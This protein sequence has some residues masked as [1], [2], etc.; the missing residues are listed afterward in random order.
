MTI[1]SKQIEKIP[2]G[3]RKGSNEIRLKD[4]NSHD[5]E[6][7][8]QAI[9]KEWETNLSNGAIKAVDPQRAQK[10]RQQNPSRIMQS[11]LLHVAKPIMT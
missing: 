11:R 3:S 7:F 2:P 8:K 6:L 4:L 5:Y 9:K 1:D 10:I